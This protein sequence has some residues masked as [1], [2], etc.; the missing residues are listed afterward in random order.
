MVIM[1][2]AS[3]WTLA[4]TV[5]ADCRAIG[6]RLSNNILLASDCKERAMITQHIITKIRIFSVV[7]LNI[8]LFRLRFVPRTA[9]KSL[10]F[11]VMFLSLLFGKNF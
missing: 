6:L 8:R 9:R 1:R 10:C 3:I 7:F 2:S 5:L 11:L 4:S